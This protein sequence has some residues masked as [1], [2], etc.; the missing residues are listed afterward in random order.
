VLNTTFKYYAVLPANMIEKLTQNIGTI[1]LVSQNATK[2]PCCF[3]CLNVT[4]TEIIDAVVIGSNV[5]SR[6][7]EGNYYPRN[8]RGNNT[9]HSIFYSSNLVGPSVKDL[10][11]IFY[12]I[13]AGSYSLTSE[14]QGEH[15]QV[16]EAW[17]SKSQKQISS[18]LINLY[19][20][21]RSQD[22]FQ[23]I[24]SK[25]L[26]NQGFDNIVFTQDLFS[27]YT[28]YKTNVKVILDIN[29]AGTSWIPINFPNLVLNNYKRIN[30]NNINK[31]RNRILKLL[32]GNNSLKYYINNLRKGEI[33]RWEKLFQ[34]GTRQ[35]TPATSVNPSVLSTQRTPSVALGELSGLLK[36]STSQ[37][38][39]AISKRT[40]S[41]RS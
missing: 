13:I 18:Y 24:F 26:E 39:N 6:S 3:I 31:T 10:N 25:Y 7:D 17:K 1:N 21:K 15:N 22:K 2:K 5:F 11:N 4:T 20:I 32:G 41:T 40:K 28:G 23:Y 33:T 19:Y 34:I 38:N 12:N 27:A 36:R 14:A 29:L 16:R 37:Q 30:N 35:Q 9:G 8:F